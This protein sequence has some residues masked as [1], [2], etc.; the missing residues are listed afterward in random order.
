MNKIEL[1]KKEVCEYLNINIK[2]IDTKTRKREIAEARQ[3]I[4]YLSRE[5]TNATLED[6]GFQIGGRNHATVLYS[7]TVINDR[8]S[9]DKK[10]TEI[11]NFLKYKIKQYLS[12][13]VKKDGIWYIYHPKDPKSCIK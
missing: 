3:I 5:L 7:L 2:L 4:H 1:I 13:G 6:V 8:M 10:F 11:I 9:Y 12:E